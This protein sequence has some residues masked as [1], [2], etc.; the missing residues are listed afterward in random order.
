MVLEKEIGEDPNSILLFQDEAAIQIG[1]TSSKIWSKR[2]KT[3]R[4]LSSGKRESIKLIGTVNYH[5][6]DVFV[7]E[8]ADYYSQTFEGFLKNVL[9]HYPNK[10]V[11][12]VL[13]NAIRHK[14]KELKPFFY[15]NKRL[16]LV[17]LPTYTPEL[18][19]IEKLWKWM[20][21][22]VVNNKLFTHKIELWKSLFEFFESIKIEPSL[23]K[24]KLGIR[25]RHKFRGY[26]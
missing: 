1:G 12:M 20:K 3:P 16:Q 6:G 7:R 19:P 9:E 5:S 10:N 2:G 23:V 22:C 17:F 14:S 11:Y 26:L 24:Q 4:V 15:K 21:S 18:N 13:D 25:N 8:L